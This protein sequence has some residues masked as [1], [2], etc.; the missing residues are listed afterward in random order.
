MTSTI[1]LVSPVDKQPEERLQE[2]GWRYTTVTAAVLERLAQTSADVSDILL[3]DVR[4]NPGLIAELQVIRRNRPGTA[5][6]IIAR[7]DA[8]LMLDAM[9]AGIMECV[10]APIDAAQLDAALK[11]VSASPTPAKGELLAVIGVKGGVGTTTVAVNTATTLASIAKGRTLL[12]D[13]H[14]SGGDA[15]VFLGVEPHFSLLDALGNTHRLDEAFLKGIVVRTSSG[16]D[17]L[18]A[19]DRATSTP[20]DPRRIRTVVEFATRCYRFV[21]L[22]VSRLEAAADET[23]GLASRIIVVATQELTA[24]RNAS[25]TT[26]Q[27]RERYGAECVQVVLNRYD[28]SA[29]IPSE[30]LERAVGGRL[31]HK[32]PSNYR[33]AIDA[34]NKG[35]PLVIDNHNKLAAS[36]A[37]YGRLLSGTGKDDAPARPAAAGLLGR[38]TGRR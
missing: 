6:V 9:R 24:I 23:L 25:R 22:D 8:A 31:D 37:A 20:I 19:P 21:V 35:R 11:R 2:L 34:L 18:A 15:A 3:V 7:L 36:F 29:D 38:L 33:L 26:A 1:T 30:D 28:H 32:F 12:I 13:L 4:E 10:P 5:I 17:L 16:L 14:P 27:L